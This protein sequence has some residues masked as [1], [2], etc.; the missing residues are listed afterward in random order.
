LRKTRPRQLPNGVPAWFVQ[1]DRNGDGQ[2]SLNEWK[3]S[4]RPIAEF[5]AMDR[6]NDG[7]V[8]AHELLWYLNQ[9]RNPKS[10]R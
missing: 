5:L 7:F 6:N 8:T 9:S 10:D 3:H 4:G 1:L 2:L